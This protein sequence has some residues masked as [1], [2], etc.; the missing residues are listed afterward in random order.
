M[1]ARL[2]HVLFWIA[3]VVTVFTGAIALVT[4]ALALLIFGFMAHHLFFE[5][6]I[7]HWA[8][9]GVGAL[10]LAIVAGIWLIGR[11]LLDAD[12]PNRSGRIQIILP[13]LSMAAVIGLLFFLFA[14]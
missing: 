14:E 3:S 11:A 5:V 4:T 1:V 12:N 7:V 2:Q 9:I 13:W 10:F 6:E 8:S